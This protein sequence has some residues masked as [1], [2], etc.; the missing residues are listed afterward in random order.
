MISFLYSSEDIMN[1]MLDME[2]P[3][4]I[5]DWGTKDH[6]RD[7]QQQIDQMHFS[8]LETDDCPQKIEQRQ[9]LEGKF[10]VILIYLRLKSVSLVFT[11]SIAKR[12]SLKTSRAKT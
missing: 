9:K 1:K 5:L 4:R 2:A 10:N 12:F 3:H 7:L 11:T 8:Y 6:L